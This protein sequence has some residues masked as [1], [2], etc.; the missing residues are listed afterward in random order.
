M[1]AFL[2]NDWFA[3]LILIHLAFCKGFFEESEFQKSQTF[4][5]PA[6]ERV[7][8][9]SSH[10]QIQIATIRHICMVRTRTL[11]PHQD[12]QVVPP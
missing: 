11:A 1:K 6:C 7:M 12:R 9:D 3:H 2:P 5:Q 8:S 4:L 10:L